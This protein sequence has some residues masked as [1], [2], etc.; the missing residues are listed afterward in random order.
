ME[1]KC[2]E[3]VYRREDWSDSSCGRNT[4]KDGYCKMHHPENVEARRA[5]REERYKEKQK[6]SDWYNLEQANKRIAELE[7]EIKRMKGK[8]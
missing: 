5:L 6:L 2:K 1:V 7:A 4:W 8:Q 3:R